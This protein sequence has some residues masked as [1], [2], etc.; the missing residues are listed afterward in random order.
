MFELLKGFCTVLM[1]APPRIVMQWD[2]ITQSDFDRVEVAWWCIGDHEAEN[3]SRWIDSSRYLI[4][5]K[6]SKAYMIAAR[7]HFTARTFA[8]ARHYSTEWA[9]TI[10]KVPHAETK[11]QFIDLGELWVTDTPKGPAVL[12]ADLADAFG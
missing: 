11:S 9:Y 8:G 5:V 12:L 4:A 1:D 3:V 10:V 7:A 6:P 2:R